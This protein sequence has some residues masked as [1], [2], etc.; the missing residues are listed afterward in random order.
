M[1]EKEIVRNKK[2][3]EFIKKV[4]DTGK[5]TYEEINRELGEDFPAENIEHLINL[6]LEQGIKIVNEDTEDEDDEEKDDDELTD[7]KEL[8]DEYVEEETDDSL[9]DEEK[10]EDEDDVD[11]DTFIGFE[12]E[13]NPDYIEDISE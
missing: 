6:M 11:T 13:F 2:V 12:D 10:D 4:T 1:K 3:R 8:D 7:E 9:E 5:V